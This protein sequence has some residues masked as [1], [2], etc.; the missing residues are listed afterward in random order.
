MKMQQDETVLERKKA[1]LI[2]KNLN[3]LQNYFL[4][5]FH[6]KTT[7]SK[8]YIIQTFPAKKILTWDIGQ[9]AAVPS[10]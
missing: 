9:V 5:K 1:V 7:L 6:K 10:K 2:L 3:H 8:F 4:Q